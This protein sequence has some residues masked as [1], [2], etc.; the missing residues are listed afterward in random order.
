MA[1]NIKCESAEAREVVKL[2]A[3]NSPDVQLL[4]ILFLLFL[5]QISKSFHCAFQ[6]R[7]REAFAGDPHGGATFI[8][9]PP[10]GPVP[11]A[12]QLGP[13]ARGHGHHHRAVRAAGTDR[14]G[15]AAPA[16]HR[17]NMRPIVSFSKSAVGQSKSI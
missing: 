2:S 17:P 14:Q 6:V 16:V 11:A 1:I 10:G 5:V 15:P 12:V 4:V 9:V 13:V 3:H 7:K 8:P